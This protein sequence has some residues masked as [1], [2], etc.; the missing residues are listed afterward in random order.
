M[1]E[2]RICIDRYAGYEVQIWRWWWPFWM[3][4]RTNTFSTIDAAEKFAERYARF[5]GGCVK[6]LGRIDATSR[7]P[8]DQHS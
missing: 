7:L 4:P 6:Y 3:Q 8:S 5:G 1:A 2:Y